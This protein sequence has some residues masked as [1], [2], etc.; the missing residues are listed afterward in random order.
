MWYKRFVFWV[1]LLTTILH[2]PAVVAC[3][4]PPEATTGIRG[5]VCGFVGNA[6]VFVNARVF[7]CLCAMC[8]VCELCICVCAHTYPL[9]TDFAPIR[10]RVMT[11]SSRSNKFKTPTA[12][13]FGPKGFPTVHTHAHTHAHTRTHT[14]TLHARTLQAWF[15]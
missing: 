7:D 10:K 11:S 1:V 13:Q 2:L 5:P 6:R 15:G 14:H 8:V 4:P 12:N 3:V 9:H